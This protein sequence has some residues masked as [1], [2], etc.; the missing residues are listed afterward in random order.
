MIGYYSNS[1]AKLRVSNLKAKVQTVLLWAFR[2]HLYGLTYIGSTI[3]T[4]IHNTQHATNTHTHTHTH[5]H[6]LT[7]NDTYISTYLHTYIYNSINNKHR[8]NTSLDINTNLTF[9][10]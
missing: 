3:H 1:N 2:K 7:N 10:T 9:K 4:N 8:R 6:L 5:T